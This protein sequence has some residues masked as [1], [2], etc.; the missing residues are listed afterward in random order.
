MII[1]LKRAKYL[2]ETQKN[3]SKKTFCLLSC[4]P[5]FHQIRHLSVLIFLLVPLLIS[6][7]TKESLMLQKPTK[8]KKITIPLENAV[9]VKTINKWKN[10]CYPFLENHLRVANI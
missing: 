6:P 2:W 5:N 10:N 8:S 3:F 9:F 4:S 1:F 7:L